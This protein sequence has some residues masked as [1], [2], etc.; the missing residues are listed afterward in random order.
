[1]KRT[2]VHDVAEAAGVSI[3]TVSYVMADRPLRPSGGRRYSGETEARVKEAAHRLNY[4]PNPAAKAVR[5]G[6]TGVVQLS[7]SMLSDPWTLAVVD[8]VNAVAKQ[9]GLTTTIL[10]DGDWAEALERQ[11]TDVAFID[12]VPPGHEAAGRLRR[13]VESGQRLVVFDETLEPAGFDVVRSAALPGCSLAVEHLLES[14]T[15]IGCLTAASA[16]SSLVPSRFTPFVELLSA[17]GIEIRE[18]WVAEFTESNESAYLAATQLLGRPDRPTAIYA[19]T[20]F[21]ALAAINAAHRLGMRVPGDVAVIGVGN[22]R[23]GERS[24]PTLSTVGPECFYESVAEIVVAKALEQR[25]MPGVIHEF[26]WSLIPR[27][28]TDAGRAA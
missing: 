17:A 14:H 4:R 24:D 9:H 16:R 11:P 19:T 18:G 22:T 6:Q 23:A 5:T 26:P 12:N 8:S 1:M 15:R 10:A 7:L 3:A 28:S 2:T 27:E 25:P 13:L 20:D 21:A